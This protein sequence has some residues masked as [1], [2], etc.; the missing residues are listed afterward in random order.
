ME[1][2]RTSINQVVE[3]LMMILPLIAKNFSR[4]IRNQTN[5]TPG[6]LFTLGALSHHDKLTMSGISNHLSVPKSHV[7]ALV[8]RLIAEELVERLNDPNDRRI[9]YI[10]ITEKGRAK[11][12]EVK[13]LMNNELGKKLLSLN[14][15]QLQL[16]LDSSGQV[17]DILLEIFREQQACSGLPCCKNELPE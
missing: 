10:Q 8:D 2:D 3:N 16:L 6:V 4:I 17:K 9:I 15:E 14:E 12:K 1:N 11:F 7:T 13:V 5:F